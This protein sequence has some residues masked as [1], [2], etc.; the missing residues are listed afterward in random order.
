MANSV[1]N[2][3]LKVTRD[4]SQLKFNNPGRFMEDFDPEHSKREMRKVHRRFYRE[5]SVFSGSVTAT[6][7]TTTL[8]YQPVS[9]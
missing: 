9:R 4:V 6:P 8:V 1:N 2:D 5:G 3:L 7:I